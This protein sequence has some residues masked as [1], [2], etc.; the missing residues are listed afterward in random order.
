M[1]RGN[2]NR[3]ALSLLLLAVVA[4]VVA[5]WFLVADSV[6]RSGAI[7]GDTSAL[8]TMLDVGQADSIFVR[9]PAGRTMLVDAGN[10][11]ADAEKVILPF[12]ARQGVAKLDYLV[13]THPD[14]DHVG[15][16]PALLDGIPVGAFVDSVQPGITNQAY[17]QTL[18]RVQSKGITPI[19]ARRG[20]AELDLG[21]GV[22]LQIL[23]PEDPLLTAGSSVANENG[24]VVRV[25]YGSVSALLAADIGKEGEERLLAHNE[26]IRSQILKVGHHGSETSSSNEFLAAVNPEVGLISVGA[27]N[28][29]GLPKTQ[30]LQRLQR[31]NVATYRTD[32]NGIISVRIDGRAYTVSTERQGE[33]RDGR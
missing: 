21:T 17:N 29:Y 26:N 30:T 4:A 27:G 23:E 15:G 14:Q 13:L 5:A 19:K 16:M 31:R 18:Q 32:Q 8:L 25:T 11:R 24:V 2:P 22:Q 33:K 28:S 3:I 6:R 10:E 1:R 7:P 12:L 9:T 20:K